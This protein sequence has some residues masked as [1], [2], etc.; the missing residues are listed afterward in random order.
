MANPD[1]SPV[2]MTTQP[3]QTAFPWAGHVRLTRQQYLYAT[4]RGRMPGSFHDWQCLILA[5]GG[6]EEEFKGFGRAE[7]QRL[8]AVT[9]RWNAIPAVQAQIEYERAISLETRLA[10]PLRAWEARMER[11]LALA[12]GELPQVRTV[13][14]GEVRWREDPE[15]REKVPQRVLQVEEYVETNLTALGKALEMQGR[16]LSVFKDR[17]EVTG[18]DGAPAIQV[19]FVPPKG[20]AAS[21]QEGVDAAGA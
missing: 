10:E 4:T 15:T 14:T 11:F 5:R 21:D 1:E 3:Q 16:A 2:T 20:A 13:D 8:A 18:A 12:A 7:K 9:A 6:S 17:Q 19:L